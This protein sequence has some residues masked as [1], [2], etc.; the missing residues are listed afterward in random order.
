MRRAAGVLG[1][2]PYTL[3]QI[4]DCINIYIQY[5]YLWRRISN[6]EVK[7]FAKIRSLYETLL[8]NMSDR[9]RKNRG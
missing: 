1:I 3:F 4:L 7:F 5:G 2:I 8:I 6:E 9:V